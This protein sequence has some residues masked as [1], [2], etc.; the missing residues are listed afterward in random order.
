MEVRVIAA[1][2]A[3]EAQLAMIDPDGHRFATTGDS[4]VL[5][6]HSGSAVGLMVADKTQIRYLAS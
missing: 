6:G 3:R 1:N 4:S 5:V 2:W